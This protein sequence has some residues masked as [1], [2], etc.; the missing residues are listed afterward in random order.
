VFLDAR[1]AEVLGDQDRPPPVR[2]PPGAAAPRALLD[3]K[4]QLNYFLQKWLE[5]CLSR[6][7]HL[8]LHISA[9][10]ATCAASD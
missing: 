4:W 6:N 5:H 3:Y 10:P 9:D 2:S 1:I 8:N 7:A